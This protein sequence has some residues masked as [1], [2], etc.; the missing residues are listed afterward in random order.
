MTDLLTGSPLFYLQPQLDNN[1]L[2]P[3]RDIHF[4]FIPSNSYVSKLQINFEFTTVKSLWLDFFFLQT[5]ISIS[6]VPHAVL[7]QM[8]AAAHNFALSVIR[9]I[10]FN[11]SP[12]VNVLQIYL[13]CHSP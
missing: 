10:N 3:Q 4:T 7:L 13:S 11:L 12:P 5:K 2:K 1:N 8:P 6:F 9:L